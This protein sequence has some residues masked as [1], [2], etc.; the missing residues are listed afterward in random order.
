MYYNIYH[1]PP[2]REENMGLDIY[3]NVYDR[4]ELNECQEH[5]KEIEAEAKKQGIE[6]DYEKFRHAEP[7]KE[8]YFRKVNALVKWVENNVGAVEN[9]EMIEL[10]KEHIEKLYHDLKTDTDFNELTDDDKQEII[11]NFGTTSGFFFG[12]TDYD[13]WYWMGVKEVR[14]M[15]S[16]LLKNVDFETN[17]VQ[18][19]VWY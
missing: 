19:Y 1:Q 7:I 13:E 6:P 12:S 17:T 5:N 14:K 15:V 4:N 2:L 3:T 10:K 11:K 18:F 8:F 16:Y 9:C